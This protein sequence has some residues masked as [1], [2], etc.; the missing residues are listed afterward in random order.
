MQVCVF[1]SLIDKSVE[2]AF[3]QDEYVLVMLDKDWAVKGHT[4]VIWKEHHL[5]ASDLSLRQFRYFSEIYYEV[6]KALLDILRLPRAL[7]LKTGGLVGHFHFHCYPVPQS[8]DWKTIMQI[9]NKEVSESYSLEEHR[10]FLTLLAKR[11]ERTG[12]RLKK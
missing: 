11:M 10:Q 8:T 5:N 4:L 2:D 1:C 7:T 9:F 3:Y 6:E 12:S